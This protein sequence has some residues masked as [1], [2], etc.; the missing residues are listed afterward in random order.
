[1]MRKRRGR[2]E[3]GIYRR[4]SD[5]RWVGSLSLGHDGGGKRVRRVVYGGT[6]REVQD[7]LDALRRDAGAGVKLTPG[8]VT[9]AEAVGRWLDLEVKPNRAP[10][11]VKC[12]DETARL[13]I[14]PTLG[15]VPLKDLDTLR[16]DQLQAALQAAGVSPRTRELVHA[17]LSRCLRRAVKW[18]LI[19]VNPAAGA[20]RPKVTRREVP[21]TSPVQAEAL[22]TAAAGHRL[23]ALFTVIVG[24]GLRQGEAFGLRWRDVDL[25]AGLLTVRHSLEE[26]RGVV[27]L[28]SPKSASGVRSVELPNAVR[29]AL[30]AHLRQ[31][32]KDGRG[33]PDAP[34]FC[35]TEG[36]WLRKSN[37]LRNVYAPIVK[38]AGLEGVRFHDWRHYH[39]GMLIELG[40]DAKV[41]QQRIGH[42]DVSTTLR[43][44]VHPR[45]EA[46]RAAADKFDGLFG[47]GAK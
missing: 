23:A 7:K 45:Q 47:T 15:R 26:L 10:A 5:G 11:T 8:K 6:K 40:V 36:G 44:Y 29:E 21:R 34:V 24:T 17:V 16:I 25:A 19:G 4:E 9:V 37:F 32:A 43:F 33:G 39:A 42:K 41:V 28:K 12:Y 30:R 18:G 35:D 31:A 27:R 3:N 22:L 38:A 13:H 14:L 46:H 1:M 2:G 20:E